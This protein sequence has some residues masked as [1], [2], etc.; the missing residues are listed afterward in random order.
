MISP[1]LIVTVCPPFSIFQAINM[2]YTVLSVLLVTCLLSTTFLHSAEGNYLRFGRT[3][4][5]KKLRA[6]PR[7]QVQ[8]DDALAPNKQRGTGNRLQDD[9]Y[10][11]RYNW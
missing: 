9:A 3:I 11:P 2:K 7:F 10:L 6:R 1:N 5:K 8:T 4:S